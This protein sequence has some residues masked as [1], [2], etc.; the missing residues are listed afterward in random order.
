MAQITRRLLTLAMAFSVLAASTARA[1]S[2]D[3]ALAA[4]AESRWDDAIRLHTAAI[5]ADPGRADLWVRISDI[6]ARRGNLPG[7]IAALQGA[8]AAAPGTASVYARLSQA[9]SMSGHPAAALEAIEGALLLEPKSSEYL[10]A[11]AELSAWLGDYGRAQNSYR[12]LAELQPADPDNALAYARVSAWAGDTNQAVTEY[13]RYLKTHPENRDAWIELA[14]TESWRGNYGAALSALKTYKKQFGETTAYAQTYAA[15]MTGSG[16]PA[17]AVEVVTPLLAQTPDDLQLNLTHTI[18]LAMQHRSREAYSS[19]ETV[20]RLAPATRDAQDAERVVRTLLA[21]TVEPAFTAYSDSDRLQ[22]QRFAPRGTVAFA[23]GTHISAGY[24]RTILSARNGSGLDSLDGSD[25]ADYQQAW[26]GG[27][28]KLGGLTLDGQVGYAKPGAREL[29]TYSVGIS[30]RAGDSLQ[31]SLQR[32]SGAVVISPRTV[33]IGLTQIAHQLQMQWAPTLPIIVALSAQVQDFSDGNRRVEWTVAPR[34]SIAR[35][36]AFNIDLGVSAYRLETE[37]D[38][39]HGYYDPKRYEQFGLTAFPYFK[40]TENVGLAMSATVGPQR[41][42]NSPSF[43][44][45]GTISGEATFGIY[46]PW[47]L[48]VNGSGSMN[49]RLESGAFRGAGGGIALVRRF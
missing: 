49:R 13:E 33:S 15:V 27:A 47:A 46:Q 29:V 43:H 14:K 34:L 40:F 42:S 20:R 18:A 16:H 26:V 6:E 7:C 12:R 17:R 30:A 19:L 4:E 37:Q 25:S 22:I 1:Q 24:D 8:A 31:L 23:S 35:T 39:A 45:G 41:D 32:S 10:H 2:P 28:Q 38:L 21:S 3:A 9:Y 36:A 48:K 11:R 44:F 5:E